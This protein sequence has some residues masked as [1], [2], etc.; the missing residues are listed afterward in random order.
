MRIFPL[1]LLVTAT[2]TSSLTERCLAQ[3]V[4]AE[5]DGSA[6]S[7]TQIDPDN[8]VGNSLLIDASGNPHVTY[9]TYN[10][11]SASGQLRYATRVSGT[12]TTRSLEG[13]GE[14]YGNPY[15]NT[16][17]AYNPVTMRMNVLYVS[18][19]DTF[20]DP[21][22]QTYWKNYRVGDISPTGYTSEVVGELGRWY[23]SEGRYSSLA[24][25]ADGTSHISYVNSG[26]CLGSP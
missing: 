26:E 21:I 16:S 6:W 19:L 5:F 22:N 20:Y 1:S 24:V 25:S 10:A 7:Y 14:T 23:P 3:V 9:A 2:L 4:F 15:I 18:S 11:A 17:L 13:L 8:G 12:W